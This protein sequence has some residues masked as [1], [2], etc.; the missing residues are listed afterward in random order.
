MEAT[1]RGPSA[2]TLL[3]N[4][5]QVHFSTKQLLYNCIHLDH[6]WASGTPE[7]QV[8]H[9]CALCNESIYINIRAV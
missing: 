5:H 1:H 6:V 4:K 7:N 8:D 9:S 2:L 3:P